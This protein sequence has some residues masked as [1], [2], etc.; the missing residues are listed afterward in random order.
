MCEH[1]GRWLTE[2]PRH[3]TS[4]ESEKH[5]RVTEVNA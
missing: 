5:E 4:T 1:I 2:A 3:E